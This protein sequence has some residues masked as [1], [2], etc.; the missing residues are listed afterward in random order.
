MPANRTFNIV[1]V[2]ANH[3]AGVEVGT[4]DQSVDYTGAEVTVTVN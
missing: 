4:G 2:G 3:G 1:R